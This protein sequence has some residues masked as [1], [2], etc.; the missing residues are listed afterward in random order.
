MSQSESKDQWFYQFIQSNQ[1][2]E[3]S[4]DIDGA[5]GTPT[6]FVNYAVIKEGKRVGVAGIGLTLESITQLI[7]HYS[8]GKGGIVYLV[9]HR[10]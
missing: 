5:T 9:D 2:F 3:L 10:G 6:L 7:S 8:V 4:L 1:P